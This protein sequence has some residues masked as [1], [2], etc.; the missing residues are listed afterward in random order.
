[1]AAAP[2]VDESSNVVPPTTP[3]TTTPLRSN[4][5]KAFSHFKVGTDQI[6]CVPL[7]E[8]EL[9]PEP[10]CL[11]PGCMDASCIKHV[12]TGDNDVR[13]A[14]I[15]IIGVLIGFMIGYAIY[16]KK[17]NREEADKVNVENTPPAEPI[18]IKA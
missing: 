5:L 1:M 3:D 8:I 11:K 4:R 17:K 2:M 15:G 9:K 14:F 13:Y 6:Y 10:A 12:R 18:Y 7:E 16:I